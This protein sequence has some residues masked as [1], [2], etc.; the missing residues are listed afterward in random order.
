MRFAPVLFLGVLAAWA[1]QLA[2][3]IQAPPPAIPQQFRDAPLPPETAT[4]ARAGQGTTL[5]SI[6]EP[7]DEEQHYLEFINRTRIDPVGESHWLTNVTD[8]DVLSAYNQFKVDLSVFIADTSVLP[9]VPPLAFEPRLIQAARGHSQWML[10]AGLQSHDEINPDNGQVLNTSGQRVTAAGYIWTTVGE[11]IYASARSP[12]QGHAGFEVDWGLFLED[13]QG[14]PVLDELGRMIPIAPGMQ[15]PPGHRINNHNASYREV[16]VGVINGT[17]ANGTGPQSVTINFASRAGLVPLVT[18]VV[19]FD[20][21]SNGLYDAGEGLSGVTVNVSD[22]GHHAVSAGS[23]GYA[24]PTANGARTVTFTATGLA[25]QTQNVT[26]VGG[27]NVKADLRLT[28]IPPTVSG[29]ATPGVGFANAYSLTPVPGA[30]KYVVRSGPLSAWSGVEG[31]ENGTANVTTQTTAGYTVVNTGYKRT[32][33][34]GFHLGHLQPPPSPNDQWLTLNQRF[35]VQ[36]GGRLVFWTRLGFATPDETAVAQ[37]STDDG[38]TW[39]TVW[40]QP[41]NGAVNSGGI[42]NT[43]SQR[44]VMLTDY[45]DRQVRVRFGF[46]FAGG[47][48][49]PL[50]AGPNY[51]NT[52]F[53]LDDIAFENVAVLGTFTEQEVT[54]GTGFSFTPVLETQ[55]LLSARPVA[56]TR[57]LPPGPSL[58][59]TAST[60]V[61]PVALSIVDLTSGP[62][63]RLRLDFM[64]TSGSPAEFILERKPSLT[65]AT[66]TT[67]GD[68]TLS[69]DAPGSYSFRFF[70]Q[71]EVEFLRVRTP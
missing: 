67:V 10:D 2:A 14:N 53:F 60:Q 56:G 66:W 44:A 62:N 59:V 57:E 12:L 39:T 19:Y 31:A 70:P 26:I 11:S 5:Y 22:S 29:P 43:F 17:G 34:A 54:G 8:P 20:L 3:Q 51:N 28:Y 24:V 58:L 36:T 63:G 50:A 69:N 47:S 18:G 71:G 35:L 1:F 41:G 40:S 6:G 52:G 16:G 46:R 45:I 55:Y 4:P 65:A 37:V 38:A 7:M 33:T 27:Q 42:E 68:A 32:G 49:F 23:G 15:D 30:T 13:E 48:F 64:V 21:D 61:Q 25:P 9:P